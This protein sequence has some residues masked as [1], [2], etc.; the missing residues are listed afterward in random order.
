MPKLWFINQVIG[1]NL[2]LYKEI[3]KKLW[4]RFFFKLLTLDYDRRKSFLRP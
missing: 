4:K 3:K 1:F 2:Y